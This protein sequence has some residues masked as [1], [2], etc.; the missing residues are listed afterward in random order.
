MAAIEEEVGAAPC[1]GRR[2][3][4]R[5]AAWVLRGIV[6]CALA[7]DSGWCNSVEKKIYI[8]LNRTATCVRLLNATHQIG[9]Q[10]SMNGDTG[11]IHVA[12]KE[13]DLKWVLSDGRHP[14][15]MVLLDGKLF[16]GQVME[17]LKGSS[18]IAG[19]AVAI[20][21]G[22]PA[23]GFSPGLQCPNDGYGVYN[24]SYGPEYAHCSVTKWNY[25]GNSLS[26]LD[27]GFPIFLLQNETETKVIK[28]CYQTYNTP[29]NGSGPEYPLCAMQ[30]SSHM[31]AVTSTVTCMRRSIIQSTFSL[32]PEV[33]CDPLADYN[34]WSTVRPLNDSE[35]LDPKSVVIASSRIDSHS[36]FWNVAPGAESAVASFVTLLAA[37]EAVHK[38]PDV[39]S[40]P[41]NIMFAFFQGENF[42]YIG[43]SRMVYDMQNDRFPIKLE[44][45][46][47]FL[48]LSQV[49]LR[50]SAP[51]WVGRCPLS[52][53]DALRVPILQN[54]QKMMEALNKSSENTSVVMSEIGVS[55]PLPPSSFQRFLRVQ[56]I[57]GVVLAD[58]YSH[59]ENR[60]YQS[61]YDTPE[62]IRLNYSGLT[63]EEALNHVTDTAKSLAAVATVVGRTLYKMAGGG[64]NASSIQADPLTVTRMLYGFL[65]QSNNSWFQAITKPDFKGP[66]GD[67]PLQYYIAVSSPVNS[68]SLVQS[69]LA[70]LTG[71]RLGDNITKEHCRASKEDLYDYMWVQG[72]PYPN[73]SSPRK[74]FCVRLT[75][76]RTPASSPAFELREWGSTEFSTWTESRW[77]E[78]HGRI[79]LVASKE[80]EIITLVL[81]LVILIVS[82]VATYFINAK[83]HVLFSTPGDSE[84]VAY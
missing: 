40:L 81:G 7:P 17:K 43:S 28:Q 74:P 54:I 34:V 52:R 67:E 10:S 60:Y 83:A 16:T 35:K 65:I 55:Q 76:R 14:P 9:C 68:T 63:P 75:V 50:C 69:V 30:L 47:S 58:H 22:S 36:F 82:F 38:I 61:I 4:A 8:P 71:T 24:S 48:E 11:V 66:L 46:D 37:A 39:Q 33:V 73:A 1:S 44:N 32:N 42:D 18:R 84:T 23:E 77:K 59:F 53:H 27:F 5:A 45:I 41:K 72:S 25:L 13:S 20:S 80:L 2:M 51:L 57:P 21:K 15:Y 26:Y 62:N 31:H 3:K 70:N 29:Q 12:E 6:L 56:Q 78:L 64:G 79:F 49:S 19:V